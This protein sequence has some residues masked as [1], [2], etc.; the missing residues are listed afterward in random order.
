VTRRS[1]P[2]W[3]TPDALSKRPVPVNSPDSIT[4]PQARACSHSGM[5]RSRSVSTFGQ[6]A[7]TARDTRVGPRSRG[8]SSHETVGG[9]VV[10]RLGEEGQEVFAV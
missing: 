8:H 7:R 5:W 9:V 10:G 1:E 4:H 3:P 2:P 6:S